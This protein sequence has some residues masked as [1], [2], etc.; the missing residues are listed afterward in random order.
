M[1]EACPFLD[2]VI[3]DDKTALTKSVLVDEGGQRPP[4]HPFSNIPEEQIKTASRD[5]PDTLNRRELILT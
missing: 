3:P 2:S 4:C 5:I 1:K